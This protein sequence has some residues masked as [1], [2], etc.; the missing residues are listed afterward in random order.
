MSRP[1]FDPT[2]NLGHV[3][4]ILS[5]IISGIVAYIGVKV[6]LSNVDTRLA[7]VE[8]TMQ[9]VATILITQAR[10]DERIN[11]LERQYRGN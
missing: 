11:T 7:L 3:L 1:K 8:R 10:Q 5:F 4:T 9:S 2:I 6:E